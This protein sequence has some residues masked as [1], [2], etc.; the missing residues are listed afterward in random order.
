MI[1]NLVIA[2][3][4]QVGGL[5][6]ACAMVAFT[7]HFNGISVWSGMDQQGYYTFV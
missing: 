7:P 2:H 1:G 3:G 6:M 5:I 4:W